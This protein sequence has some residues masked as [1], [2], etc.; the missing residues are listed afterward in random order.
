M[1]KYIA[2]LMLC[3]INNAYGAEV[4]GITK[5]VSQGLFVIGNKSF[6]IADLASLTREEQEILIESARPNRL[7]SCLTGTNNQLFLDK[8]RSCIFSPI[9]G[10]GL[11]DLKKLPPHIKKDLSVQAVNDDLYMFYEW[12]VM[13]GSLTGFCLVPLE[14]GCTWS[15][16][17]WA[18]GFATCP[19]ATVCLMQRV[20]QWFR[21]KTYLVDEG[22][23][24]ENN[25]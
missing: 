18:C 14:L 25:E 3:L 1:Q 13:P 24:L 12:L 16:M 23:Y 8:E 2:F 20:K 21:S 19:A 7:T 5:N 11:N 22:R 9:C 10:A 15:A 17:G 6:V 4:V